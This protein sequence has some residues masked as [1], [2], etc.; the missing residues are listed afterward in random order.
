MHGRGS[1]ASAPASD[2]AGMPQTARPCR[3][4]PRRATWQVP[5]RADAAEIGADAVEIGA[6]AV[7]IGADAAKIGPTRSV[8]AVSACIG[9]V[10]PKFKKKKKKVQTHR[11]TNLK[12]QTLLRPSHF[13]QHSQTAS[14]T[15]S[16]ISLLCVLHP[17]SLFSVFRALCECCVHIALLQPSGV[18]SLLFS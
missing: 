1:Q 7:E 2:A 5:N 12:T 9:R 18:L 10:R 11:L 4:G 3:V 15:L 16:L 13:I 14:L 8:S 6:D 17:S